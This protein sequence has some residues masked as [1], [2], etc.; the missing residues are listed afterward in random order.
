VCHAGT[1]CLVCSAH[2][3]AVLQ[4]LSYVLIAIIEDEIDRNLLCFCT[5][6]NDDD[7]D[8]DDD[9]DKDFDRNTRF[10]NAIDETK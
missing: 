9:G 5:Q 6:N 3:V 1:V 7:V 8:D 2:I 4:C 10:R